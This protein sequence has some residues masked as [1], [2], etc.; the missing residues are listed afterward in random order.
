VIRQ[1]DVGRVLRSGGGGLATL[2]HDHGYADQSHLTRDF[3]RIAGLPPGR[4]AHELRSG[5]IVQD[6]RRDE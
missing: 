6:D 5:G 1:N 4:F 3:T 2:A